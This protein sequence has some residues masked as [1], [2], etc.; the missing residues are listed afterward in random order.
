[1]GELRHSGQCSFHPMSPKWTPRLQLPNEG[2]SALTG[3][4]LGSRWWPE[5]F[6]LFILNNPLKQSGRS[7]FSD[8]DT[9]AVRAQRLSGP[10]GLGCRG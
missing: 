9:A 7:H 8:E 5:D 2:R 1:M 10:C 6:M 4:L 3:S